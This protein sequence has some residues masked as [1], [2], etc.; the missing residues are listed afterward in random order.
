MKKPLDLH[1]LCSLEEDNSFGDHLL[2]F[3]ADLGGWCL[4]RG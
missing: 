4:S 3:R 2:L 1:L